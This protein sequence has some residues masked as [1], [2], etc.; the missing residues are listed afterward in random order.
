MRKSSDQRWINTK[1]PKNPQALLKHDEKQQ[2]QLEIAIPGGLVTSKLDL[3]VA[4]EN[5]ESSLPVELSAP[6]PMHRE[7]RFEITV[8]HVPPTSKV[9]GLACAE[10]IKA[11]ASP[12]AVPPSDVCLSDP[13]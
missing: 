12:A 11:D 9:S 13:L 5:M 8:D 3:R 7:I 6:D 10:N 4:V 1:K 2:A